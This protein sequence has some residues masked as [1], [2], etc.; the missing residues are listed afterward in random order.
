[1]VSKTGGVSGVGTA[2]STE[3]VSQKFFGTLIYEV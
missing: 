2:G 3:A 1:M